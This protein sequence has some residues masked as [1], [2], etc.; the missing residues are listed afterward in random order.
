MRQ[1]PSLDSF[2]KVA[3]A[4]KY[5]VK[6]HDTLHF[7]PWIIPLVIIHYL[8]V[9]AEALSFASTNLLRADHLAM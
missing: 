9:F 7:M 5:V 6:P 2:T 8:K 4:S 3:T 1:K